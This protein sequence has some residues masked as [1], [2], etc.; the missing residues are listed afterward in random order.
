M[1]TGLIEETGVVVKTVPSGTG[2][3]LTVSADV[4]LQ[5]TA[6]GD[7]I[8]IDGACQ[9]VTRIGGGSFSFFCSRVTLQATTLGS[10]GP[11]RRVNLERAMTASGR[12]GGHIVQGHV[13]GRG[14]ISSVRRDSDGME[15]VIRVSESMGGYI[16]PKG[17]VAVDGVSLTVVS[18]EPGGFGLYI[19]PETVSK[20]TL[21]E[22]KAGDSVNIEVDILAKYVERMMGRRETGEADAGEEVLKRKLM[23]GGYL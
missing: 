16:V 21:P 19:I 5:G 17:S 20:T 8:S 1:F 3:T 23:E 9:T 13:D 15:I 22:R 6:V 4:V 18:L 10:F 7:S 12:F 14:V 2:A 11:G